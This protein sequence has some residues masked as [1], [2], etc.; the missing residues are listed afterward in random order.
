MIV[1]P[2]DHDYCLKKVK[3]V[4]NEINIEEEIEEDESEED[5]L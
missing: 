2:C 3:L 1:V 5:E 4:E